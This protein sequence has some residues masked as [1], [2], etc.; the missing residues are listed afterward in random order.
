MQ[1]AVT[2]KLD[3]SFQPVPIPSDDDWLRSH[4][5]K[6][7][8]MKAFE[9]KT[10]K[11][12]PHATHKTIY[13][14][15][16][17]SFDH[18]R[19][20]PFNIIIEFVR[21]F[22]PGCEVELLS[23]IDFS[24]DMRY[25]EKDGIRQYQTAGFY[26]YLSRIRHK[27]NSRRELVCV[28]ITM[29]DIYVDEVEDWVYGQARII[30]GLSVYSFARLDPLYPASPQT[31]F[32]S[33]LTDEHRVIMIR[34]CVKILLHELGHLFGLKHC[35][36]YICLMN[37]ANN[38]TEMDRQPLYLCPICLRKLYSTFHFNVCDVYEKFANI[39]EKYRLE[40]EHKWYW[41]RLDCIQNPNK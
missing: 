33:P 11:A 26:K 20:I 5:E 13:I 8:T 21:I 15:P 34:R 32:L 18:P 28:A 16:I 4:K 35:I 30:D 19:V 12:V 25:R 24:E 7:Q 2:S 10:S 41:K 17:G 23:A 22:F 1:I 3:E 38:E 29:A 36:Y 9:R 27:R 6:G 39:C 31:L 40:E 37:G 14:Q